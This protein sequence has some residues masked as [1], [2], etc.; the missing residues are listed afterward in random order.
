M[1]RRD[2]YTYDDGIVLRNKLGIRD[3]DE[4]VMVE[5]QVVIAKMID[6]EEVT[7]NLDPFDPSILQRIHAHLFEDLYEWAGSYRTINI[8]KE[9]KVLAWRSVEYSARADIP[10]DLAYVL[11]S[12]ANVTWTHDNRDLPFEFSKLMVGLWK[13]HK[14]Q[15][16]SPRLQAGGRNG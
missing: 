14:F 2:P 6:I 4:L 15:P 8:Y 7:Q 11:K 3:K 12:A 1:N 10:K 5:S 13:V 16:G 9:E